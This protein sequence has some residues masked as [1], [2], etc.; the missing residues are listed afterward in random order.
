M[1]VEVFCWVDRV[2]SSEE[3][4]C[5]T[6]DP[7]VHLSVSSI[8]FVCVFVC[9]KFESWIT[10]VCSPYIVSLCNFACYVLG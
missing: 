6:C 1:W 4:A 5:C 3:C 2:W 9:R 10:G 8:G 7:S